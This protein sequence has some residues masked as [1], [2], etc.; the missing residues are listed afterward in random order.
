MLPLQISVILSILDFFLFPFGISR[1]LVGEA[2]ICISNTF[3]QLG[4]LV[5]CPSHS[6]FALNCCLQLG[7]KQVKD[8]WGGTAMSSSFSFA[9]SIVKFSL[10]EG[11]VAFRPTHSSFARTSVPQWGHLVLNSAIWTI[12]SVEN[13][14][15]GL[16]ISTKKRG[17]LWKLPQSRLPQRHVSTHQNVPWS[18]STDTL[19]WNAHM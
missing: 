10:H 1:S 9:F 11:H 3:P 4:Q 8:S 19:I 13:P 7:Q 18:I 12:L 2:G 14:I 6:M 17:T 5:V 16:R 15:L